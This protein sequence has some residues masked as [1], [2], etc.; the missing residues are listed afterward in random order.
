[1][2]AGGNSP[3][4][5]AAV[6]GLFSGGQTYHVGF[7]AI[8]GSVTDQTF[9]DE[10]SS[11]TSHM[12]NGTHTA[13]WVSASTAGYMLVG[14]TTQLVSPSRFEV[15]GS[16]SG[17]A[18]PL[19]VFGNTAGSFTHV[20]HVRNSSGLGKIGVAGATNSILTG[21]AGGDIVFGNF[22]ASKR[23][24][25]TG[26]TA[27]VI[28]VK[29]DNTLGFFGVTEVAQQNAVG[30]ATGYAAGATAA[31]FHSDDTYTGNTGATAYTINGVV[32]ALKVYGLLAA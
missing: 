23:V 5:A 9:R 11:T 17:S 30:A 4:A 21:T 2:T 27:L 28:S 13:A 10:S 6:V 20:I 25:I 1:M 16:A 31:T 29:N 3:V 32:H 8:A 26:G 12:V 18:D 7:A 15:Q 19:V 24:L 22:T 14:G